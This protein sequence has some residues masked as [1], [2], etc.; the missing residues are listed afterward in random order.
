MYVPARFLRPVG[1]QPLC[2]ENIHAIGS[3][4]DHPV[5]GDAPLDDPQRLLNIL[6]RLLLLPVGGVVIVLYRLVLGQGRL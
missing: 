5:T 4:I 1:L 3:E 2:H 6:L